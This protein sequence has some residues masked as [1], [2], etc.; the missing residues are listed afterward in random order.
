MAVLYAHLH[1]DPPKLSERRKGCPPGLDA[2]IAK[3]LDKSPDRRFATCEELI[4]AARVVDRRGRPAGGVLVVAPAPVVGRRR[5]YP[6]RRPDS[7]PTPTGQRDPAR[8]RPLVDLHADRRDR[9]RRPARDRAARRPGR[10]RPRAPRASR[11]AS[12]CEIIEAADARGDAGARARP[13]ARR[14]ARRRQR[15]AAPAVAPRCAPTRSRATR[16]SCCSAPAATPAAARSR[17]WAPTTRWPR[18]SRRCSCRSSCASCSGPAPSPDERSGPRMWL[19]VRTG[20]DAGTAVELPAS[21]PFVLGRQRGCDLIVRDT[22]ASRRHVGADARRRRR[23]APA[24]PRVGQRHVRGRPPGRGGAA[25]GRR[26]AS[27]SATR[28]RGDV[29]A[30]PPPAEPVPMAT[31]RTPAGATAMAPRVAT[32]SMVR[33]LVDAGTQRASRTALLAGAARRGGGPVVVVLLATGVLGGERR[34]GA[35]RGRARRARDRAGRDARGGTRSGTGSGWVL[36]AAAGLIVTNAH[37]VNQGDDVPGRGGRAHAAASVARLRRARTSRCCRC[38]PRRGCV[39]APLAPA[40]RVE[41]GETVVALGFPARRC[42]P[43]TRSA[44]R[45]ASSP[46]RAR[47]SATRRPTSPPTRASC[48]P[49]PR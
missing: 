36:D 26:G 24:R 45:P 48:R 1:D 5:R 41:Q 31:H 9:A 23:P 20:P 18:R 38:G 16:R 30:R 6:Q 14:R 21:G 33:R 25:R 37:V 46:A 34:R 2:V 7:L 40:G 32:Q 11:S 49:T 44:R 15:A 28:A 3:A 42:A 22:R 19:H 39:T 8:R 35:A 43:A 29:A 27:G 13:P 4:L 12:A 10:G 17:P 47:P